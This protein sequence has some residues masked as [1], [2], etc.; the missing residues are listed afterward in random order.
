MEDSAALRSLSRKGD[1]V[2]TFDSLRVHSGG[3]T[4]VV[5]GVAFRKRR[6]G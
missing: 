3:G 1:E 2:L 5:W 6:S 4:H